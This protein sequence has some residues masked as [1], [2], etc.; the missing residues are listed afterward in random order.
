MF[1][2]CIETVKHSCVQS[3]LS[4][5]QGGTQ[6][7]NIVIYYIY[8]SG[9]T[10]IPQSI[11][12]EEVVTVKAQIKESLIDYVVIALGCLIMA[13][14]INTFL[15]PHN[16]LS[17]G[18]S[19]LVMIIYFFTAFPMGIASILL[20]IPLFYFAYRHLGI[21]YC[22][23][24]L[25]GMLVFSLLL[26][27]TAF[28]RDINALD[29]IML[30]SIYGG[31]LDGLGAGMLFRSN[32]HS[33][34]SDII[35]SIVNKYYGIGIGTVATIFNVILML[36]S[37]FTFGLKPSLYALTSMVITGF[38]IN[39]VIDG[40][41]FKKK[42]III[43]DKYETIAERIMADTNR[44]VTYVSAQGAYT[45]LEKRMIFVVV[46]LRQVMMV[47]NIIE[48]CDPQAFMIISDVRDVFGKGF[49]LPDD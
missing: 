28:L 49:T 20:N 41:D 30:A 25:Y 31:V 1:Y 26:D 16:M 5:L 19:G 12:L 47:R 36:V 44:G 11:L 38:V 9:G 29:D 13:A 8:R 17:S 32:A 39:R 48:E 24:G 7:V 4:N 33:G 34:G 22:I 40:F 10:H 42:I 35:G 23:N 37:T 6:T 14:S 46:K 43:S 21:R 45:N 15:V 18:L 3:N 2:W 27:A